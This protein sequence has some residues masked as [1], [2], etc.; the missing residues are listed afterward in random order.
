MMIK[1]KYFMG[2]PINSL[3]PSDNTAPSRYWNICWLLISDVL[4]CHSYES[5]ST[6]N[7]Q[8]T[9]LYDE[10]QNYDSKALPYFPGTNEINTTLACTKHIQFVLQQGYLIR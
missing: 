9:I 10:F 6:P 7:A 4:E 1:K 8:G 2:Q 5:N 3:C